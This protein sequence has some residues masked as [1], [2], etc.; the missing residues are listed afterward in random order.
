MAVLILPSALPSLPPRYLTSFVFECCEPTRQRAV[1]EAE[2]CDAQGAAAAPARVRTSV[3][4]GVSPDR[5]RRGGGLYQDPQH[6]QL[7]LCSV[8]DALPTAN[9]KAISPARSCQVLRRVEEITLS[10]KDQE[11][12]EQFKSKDRPKQSQEFSLGCTCHRLCCL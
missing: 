6:R 10:L 8:T 7:P 11:F 5:G 9:P 2:P 4:V 12:V 1:P 3:A